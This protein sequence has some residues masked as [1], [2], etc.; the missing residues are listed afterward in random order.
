MAWIA[1]PEAAQSCER[2]CLVPPLPPK[3]PVGRL[4]LRGDHLDNSALI[5]KGRTADIFAHGDGRI[6]K[7]F[8]DGMPASVV[9]REYIVTREARAAGVPVPAA[10]E[11][12]EVDGRYGIV[13]ERIEGISLLAKLQTRPWELFSIA[14]QLGEL[15]AQIH[16]RRAPAELPTQRQ[17]IIYGIGAAKDIAESEKQ[18]AESCLMQLPEGESLCHGDFHPDNILLSA[19]G[20]MIIDWLTGTRGHPLGDVARTLLIIQTGGLPPGTPRHVR[21][22]VNIL[23]A[24]FPEIYLNRYL[25]LR[26]ADRKQI[27]QWRLPLAAAR[28]REVEDY[29][30]EKQLLLAQ[31]RSMIKNQSK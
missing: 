7:L 28:L 27:V 2:V 14:R 15:H 13:F 25:Q 24:V 9:E 1:F 21:L 19:R 8:Q 10:Y 30:K 3:H 20:P 23:R 26:P 6:L 29:P 11:L 18:A 31:L 17:Q 22:M 16:E 4:I 5:G 12:V